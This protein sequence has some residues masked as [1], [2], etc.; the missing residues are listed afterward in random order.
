MEKENQKARIFNEDKPPREPFGRDRARI[1]HSA[2]FRRLQGKTQVLGL[3]ES[4]FYRTRLTHSLEVAQI[5]SGILEKLSSSY[6]TEEEIAEALPSHYLIEAIC[7]AHDIGHPPFGHGGEVALNA[8]MAEHGGFEGNAQTLR[9]CAKLGEYT[10]KNGLNLTRRTLLGVLKYP[11]LYSDAVNKG[12]YP[13]NIHS[14]TDG[15]K[16]IDKF[17]PP[18]CIFDCDQE[19][20]NWV[21]HPFATDKDLFS[22]KNDGGVKHHKP[23]Y[24]SL[25]T[26]IMEL[27]DDIAYGVHDLEDAAALRLVS[28]KD[29]RD[30]GVKE[31]FKGLPLE[32]KIEEMGRQIFSSDGK[33]RKYAI[34]NLV[35]NFISKV[36]IARQG[37]FS[38]KLLDLNSYLPKEEKK[39]LKILK[40]FVDQK[41]IKTAEVQTLEFKGQQMIVRLFEA[42]ANNPERLLPEK[43]REKY[44]KDK[45][46]RVICDYL[47]GTTD[48]YATRLY[49]KIFTPSSGSIFDR[50]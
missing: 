10:E 38:E 12:I 6:S 15:T 49:H 30:F 18:K 9:I 13:T 23:I 17:K 21:C 47:A 8:M 35:H 5:A 29:W 34:G 44:E 16:N 37:L 40:E 26:S 4:D 2:S 41:V 20:F 3:G 33:E 1:I 31:K 7:L 32:D 24:K 46:L 14:I 42:I 28:E 25:D 19:V 27:A 50:L 22:S 45:S 39:Q 43:Y 11:V 48:D 36:A